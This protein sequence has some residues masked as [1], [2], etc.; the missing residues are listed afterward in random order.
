[1]VTKLPIELT[2]DHVLAEHLAAERL[3]YKSTRFWKVDKVVAVALAGFGAYVVYM[4]GLRWWSVVLFPLAIAEW[5]N[6][7][8]LYPFQ[9]R[10]WFKHNPRFRETDHLFVD[11]SAL[12]FRT[13]SID[14][15]I[16]WTLVNSLLENDRLYLLVYGRRMYTLVPKRAFRT[17]A[18]LVAFRT[19]TIA[20]ISQ[21]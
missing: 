9:V 18:D 11:E 13:R 16:R 12:H 20:K 17:E 15:K 2:F 19:L 10:Y 3:Y 1:V 6:L 21:R 4:V 5:F 14:A 8:S 7:L